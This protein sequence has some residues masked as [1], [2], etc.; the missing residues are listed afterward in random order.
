MTNATITVST[1][2]D[3]ASC[4]NSDEVGQAWLVYA[5]GKGN[6]S[7]SLCSRTNPITHAQEDLKA[8]GSGQVAPLAPPRQ[9]KPIWIAFVLLVGGVAAWSSMKLKR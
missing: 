4:G 7:T 2:A 6:L 8:L 9:S 1:S 5:Y 3:G